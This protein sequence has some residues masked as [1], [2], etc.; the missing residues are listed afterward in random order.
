MIEK[1]ETFRRRLMQLLETGSFTVRDLSWELR[2]SE[3]EIYAHLPHIQRSL[4]AGNKE[5]IVS[6]YH[7][8]SCHFEF[9]DRQRISKPGRCPRCRESRIAPATFRIR[10]QREEERM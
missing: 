10:L 3:K 1:Q 7:C 4:K 2:A 9:K 8:L 5:F 6:P